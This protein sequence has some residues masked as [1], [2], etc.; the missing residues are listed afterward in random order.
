MNK[1]KPKEAS[2]I[3]AEKWGKQKRAAA[4]KNSK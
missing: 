3:Q 1:C 4:S 2:K